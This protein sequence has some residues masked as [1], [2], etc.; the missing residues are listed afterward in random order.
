MED[1]LILAIIVAIFIPIM[2]FTCR[3]FAKQEAKRWNGGYCPRCGKKLRKFDRD[4]QG[5]DGWCCDNCNYDT[6]V[7]YHR[8][9]YK[10]AKPETEQKEE[11]A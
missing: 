4:S 1:F 6:W 5:G 10:T 9:V 2:L 8:W 7:S 3:I 11:Q